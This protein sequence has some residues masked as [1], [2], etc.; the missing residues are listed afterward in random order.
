M[1]SDPEDVDDESDIEEWSIEDQTLTSDEENEP[2]ST[3]NRNRPTQRFV[4]LNFE[5]PHS[6]MTFDSMTSHAT[7][8]TQSSASV[9]VFVCFLFINLIVSFHYKL[10]INLDLEIR[11]KFYD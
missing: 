4:Y 8:N 9:P 6:T 1:N 2:P 5:P 10:A 3:S 11:S 7:P